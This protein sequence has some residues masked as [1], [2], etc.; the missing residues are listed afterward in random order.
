[1]KKIVLSLCALSMLCSC[2]NEP[3]KS[4]EK[5]YEPTWESLREHNQNPEWFKDA[6]LGIYFHWGLYSVPAFGSEW[7]PRFMFD[8]ENVLE[9]W[10][11]GVYE[12]HVKTYG[13]DF[14]YQDFAPMFTAEHFDAEDWAQL[15]EDAG[16]KFAGPVASHHDGY[17]MWASD[18]NPWN[19]RDTGPKRDILG[20][21]F[22]A[23]DKHNL[24]TIATFHH[25]RTGQRYA[26]DTANWG[27]VNSHYPYRPDLVTSTNDPKLRYLYG[28]LEEE[29]FNKYWLDQVE[30][31]VNKYNPDIIWFDSWL[32]EM[33]ESYRQQ[34]MAAQFNAGVKAGKETVVACKQEDL[35][36]DIAV[37]DVEQGGLQE[38]GKNYWLTDVTLSNGAW[39]YTNGQVYKSLDVLVRNMIDVWSK[40]G[41]VLLNISPRA[42]GVINDEQRAL[43]HGLGQWMKANSEAIYGTRAYSIFGYGDAAHQDGHFGGQS[44]TMEYSASDVR[45]TRSADGSAFY[46]F[47]LGMPE[48]DST[49]EL[50]NIEGEV[51]GV[52]LLASATELEWELSGDK[53]S[54]KTPSADKMDRVANVFKISV[55]KK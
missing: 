32:D 20:E 50:H 11:R 25:A 7:Y 22:T 27:G 10:G 12:H 21:L 15:F 36:L 29:E 46:A 55:A 38:M 5:L 43:L 39:C 18:V 33:P 13:K 31:V 47:V 34:M 24:H 4:A 17:A 23:F 19:V 53:L 26:K 16:A 52:S 3:Q 30:E 51:T 35:P 6:K 37:L 2:G 49:L 41:I 45:F 40:R 42:D 14:E 48:G 9:E 28:N 1:M 54:V 44:A 8:T